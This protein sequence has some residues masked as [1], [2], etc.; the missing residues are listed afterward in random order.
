MLGRMLQMKA[1][2]LPLR[3]AGSMSSQWIFDRNSQPKCK[4]PK[5]GNQT[6]SRIDFA[7][8]P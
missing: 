7:K 2:I 1:S 8:W 5:T 4:I 6:D 3:I